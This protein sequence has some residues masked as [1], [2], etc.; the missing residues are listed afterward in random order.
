MSNLNQQPLHRR[1]KSMSN[2]FFLF[3]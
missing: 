2:I 1:T 3:R